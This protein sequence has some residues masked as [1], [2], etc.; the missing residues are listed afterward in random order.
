M[1]LLDYLV[2]AQQ[3][4][5]LLAFLFALWKGD[6]LLRL[7]ASGVPVFML[8]Y[9]AVDGQLR[10]MAPVMPL[11]IVIGVLGIEKILPPQSAIPE[12]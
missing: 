1:L 7:L 3:A 5:L 10:Y 11:V 2:V 9:M 12:S 8:S 6:W 4:I